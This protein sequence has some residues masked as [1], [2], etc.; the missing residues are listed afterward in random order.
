MKWFDTYNSN[1]LGASGNQSY[2]V[3]KNEEIHIG[4]V[5]YKV[6][7][8]GR[9][10]YSLLFSNIID[11]TFSDGSWSH[12]NLVCD[13]WEIKRMIIGVCTECSATIAGEMN[14]TQQ[15]TFGGEYNKKV[16]PGEFFVSDA[17]ELKAEKGEYICVEIEFSGTMMP[18]HEESVLPIFV[19]ENEKWISSKKIPVPCM[20]G[21]DR[22]VRAK[23]G[24]LGDSITQGIGT[25]I[26]SYAHWNALIADEMGN[27]F[28]YWNLGLGFGRASDAASDGAWLYKAKQMDAVVVCYGINDIGQGLKI[29]DIRNNLLNIVLQLKKAGVKVLIQSLP[30]FDYQGT[31]LRK[32]CQVNEYIRNTLSKYADDFFDVVPLLI[33]GEECD[34]KAK[35]NGH[36]NE[37]GCRMWAKML[38]PAMKKFFEDT[39]QRKEGE[40]CGE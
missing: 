31:N 10:K 38:L 32:W 34:G 40:D 36:P 22:K 28:S 24:F 17:I 37:E 4:R 14:M 19:W 33:D 27:E 8:G 30:P 26:N 6:Y 25:A 23:I 9:Y 16:M 21:C 5:Y 7:S 18:Y 11:S 29:E 39:L 1:T 13:E 2:F 35:Y 3:S 15:V 12:C 20:I